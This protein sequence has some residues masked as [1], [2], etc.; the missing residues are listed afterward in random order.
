MKCESSNIILIFRN[1]SRY[2][3][4]VYFFIL[5]KYL[6]SVSASYCGCCPYC[7][8]S[9]KIKI[10]DSLIRLSI[11][12]HFEFSSL[13]SAYDLYHASFPFVILGT[14]EQLVYLSGN[15]ELFC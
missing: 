12:I 7:N 13:C 11:V 9:Q 10:L 3:G 4:S 14:G 1:S 5:Q 6:Y 8:L 15:P 2:P